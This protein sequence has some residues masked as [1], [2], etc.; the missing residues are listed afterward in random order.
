MDV[1]F[2]DVFLF[3][4]VFEFFCHCGGAADEELVIREGVLDVF[5]YQ[6]DGY[7]AFEALVVGVV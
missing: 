4:L 5:F 1:G 3:E 6:V 7:V 2:G